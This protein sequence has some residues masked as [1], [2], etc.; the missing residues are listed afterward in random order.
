MYIH[1]YIHTE[2][3]SERKG[4]W[5]FIL[6]SSLYLKL[7]TSPHIG[8]IICLRFLCTIHA[9]ALSVPY[10]CQHDQS[11]QEREEGHSKDEEFAAVFTTEH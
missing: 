3:E 9:V 8:R 1:T 7:P 10:L 6:Y 11:H 4:P 2:R 5:H